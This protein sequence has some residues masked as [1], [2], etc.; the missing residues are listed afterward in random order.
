M[1]F[2]IFLHFVPT[3]EN[4]KG[5]KEGPFLSPRYF[6]AQHA[7]MSSNEKEV[8]NLNWKQFLRGRFEA[9]V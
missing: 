6:Q 4:I 7:E 5:R 2:N 1:F 8:Q 9:L 3:T